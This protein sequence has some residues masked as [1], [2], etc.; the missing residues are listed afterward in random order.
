MCSAA[1]TGSTMTSSASTATMMSATD[2]TWSSSH[3]HLLQIC[4]TSLKPKCTGLPQVM[5][6]SL[7][8]YVNTAE[9]VQR[10]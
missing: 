9:K 7:W 10:H 4:L 1:H 2:P 6:P 3:S 8:K 5:S